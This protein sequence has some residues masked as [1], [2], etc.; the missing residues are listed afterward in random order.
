MM[1]KLHLFRQVGVGYH[2]MEIV[3]GNPT[4]ASLSRG[5][6]ARAD[7]LP[8]LLISILQ[9][10]TL[11]VDPLGVVLKPPEGYSG[12]YLPLDGKDKEDAEAFLQALD[13]GDINATNR[14]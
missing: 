9:I 11:I 5:V 12:T 2:L 4:S 7:R 3:A 10:T 8:P 1:K 6:L 14:R 13:K